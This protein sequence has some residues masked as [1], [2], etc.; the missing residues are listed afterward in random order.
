MSKPILSG[1]IRLATLK[2]STRQ[3]IK[4]SMEYHMI[5]S[6]LLAARSMWL[7]GCGLIG[8]FASI[9]VFVIFQTHRIL[10]ALRIYYHYVFDICIA[11]DGGA[12]NT[13]NGFVLQSWS[14][15]QLFGTKECIYSVGQQGWYNT[16]VNKKSIRVP[17]KYLMYSHV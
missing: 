16:E 14:K 10:D 7:I 5:F 1:G 15:M 17:G 3:S 6:Y 4:A 13:E 9:D 8:G 2:T 12:V 11:Y